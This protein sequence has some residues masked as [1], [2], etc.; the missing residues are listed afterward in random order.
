MKKSIGEIQDSYKEYTT[1]EL[2]GM[3]EKQRETYHDTI[4][5]FE[6][7]RRYEKTNDI[8]EKR[9]I[10]KYGNIP[11]KYGGRYGDLYKHP[12]FNSK[13]KG[14]F[15]DKERIFIEEHLVKKVKPLSRIP[16][17]LNG[18]C[19]IPEL[20]G[21]NL[22]VKAYIMGYCDCSEGTKFGPTLHLIDPDGEYTTPPH[23]GFSDEMSKIY[24]GKMCIVLLEFQ[25]GKVP[26]VLEVST[27]AYTL[28]DKIL[29]GTKMA[30]TLTEPP[31]PLVKRPT[32]KDWLDSI[33][34]H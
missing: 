16:S 32:D 29:P 34:E 10:S 8:I 4:E 18:E 31:A 6:T 2:K 28:T 24:E 21:L 25:K 20:N 17:L 13:W 14:T 5:D 7:V 12:E 30:D 33:F 27:L 22:P 19:D 1:E 9:F 3:L 23:F 26:T 11:H 15:Y